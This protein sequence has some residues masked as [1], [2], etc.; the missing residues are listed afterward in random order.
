MDNPYLLLWFESP[1]Q[2]WGFDSKFGRRDTFD[3]P[4]KSGVLGLLCSALGKSGKQRELLALFAPLS[5]MVL[6]FTRFN[7][8]TNEKIKSPPLLRDFQ[9]VGSGYNE[10]D[11]WE[12]LL[13]PKTSLGKKP[14]GAGTKMTY[15]YYLQDAYFAVIVEFPESMMDELMNGLKN[16]FWD[17][18]L[19]R[20][21][22]APTDFIYQGM[23]YSEQSAIK[24]ALTIGRKKGLVEYFH[25]LDGEHPGEVII[26]ND[27]PIQFGENKLYRE[28]YV[29]VIKI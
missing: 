6:S 23:F 16:P 13:V 28:R 4:T 24:T 14:T 10:N 15:R 9:M 7:K 17:L 29:T 27:I 12:S 8:H 3:F 5:Q 25:V 19:G 26:L 22:C 11:L 21:T 2:S 20:K 18:Y 1:L